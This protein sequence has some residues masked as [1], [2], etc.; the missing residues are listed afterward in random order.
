MLFSFGL[1]IYVLHINY[2]EKFEE[3]HLVQQRIKRWCKRAFS[4][5]N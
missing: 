3:W 2:T 5:K 4:C 1:V